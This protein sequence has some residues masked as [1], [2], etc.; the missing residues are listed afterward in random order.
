MKKKWKKKNIYVLAYWTLLFCCMH[1]FNLQVWINAKHL[2]IFLLLPLVCDFWLAKSSAF[3]KSQDLPVVFVV[4]VF[5]CPA[6]VHQV[7]TNI[8][9]SEMFKPF[10]LWKLTLLNFSSLL[11]MP[12]QIF[13]TFFFFLRHFF[14]FYTIRIRCIFPRYEGVWAVFSY[15]IL[16]LHKCNKR[17]K[18]KHM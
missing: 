4:N 5:E 6:S 18:M 10:M 1:I 15:Q 12:F 17:F 7:Q 13:T 11:R 3:K 8:C 14:F 2:L 16:I 9:F